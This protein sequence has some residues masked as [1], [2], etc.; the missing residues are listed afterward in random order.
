M[1]VTETHSPTTP[2]T[3]TTSTRSTPP[4]RLVPESATPPT[5]SASKP[6]RCCEQHFRHP[7]R[8]ASSDPTGV[9]VYYTRRP[10]G[11]AF[12]RARRDGRHRSGPKAQLAKSSTATARSN[13][14][15]SCCSSSRS[16]RREHRQD[17]PDDDRKRAS[18]TPPSA[19]PNTG[20]S[21][22]PAATSA[23]RNPP[24]RTP[25]TTAAG[26]PIA[27]HRRRHRNMAR[28]QPVPRTSTSP[29]PDRELLFY[30]PGQRRTT[31]RPP[32][33]RSRPPGSRCTPAGKLS[34]PIT[35]EQTARLAA[36]AEN[37]RLREGAAAQ[38]RPRGRAGRRPVQ[39]ATDARIAVVA[40]SM[41]RN[42]YC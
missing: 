1:C 19:S 28:P 18:P 24:R 30:L 31:P 4:A 13:T 12:G 22:P 29:A 37:A 26:T 3:W 27:S 6:C 20:A 7:Q 36:E 23:Q 2:S 38:R 42:R 32:P 14:A 21:T 33:R 40:A 41:N 16:P 25:H 34:P 10:S 35:T 8:R 39:V 17:R 9:N 5:S 15:G 11:S